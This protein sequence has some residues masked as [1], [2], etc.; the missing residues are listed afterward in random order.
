MSANEELNLDGMKT[1]TK[2]DITRFKVTEGS[3]IYRIL[4]PFGTDH[5]RKA[6]R[7]IQLHWGFYKADG[8]TSPLPCSYPFE[9]T[10]PICNHVKDLEGMADK[11]K[12]LGNT[13]TAEGILKDVSGIKVKRSFLLNAANKN[14][15]V[16]V[17]EIPK[18]AHDQMI[19]LMREYLNKYGKNPT[20]LKDG[21]WF[22]FSRSGKGFNTTYKVSIN[23][24]MVTLE[25]GDQVEK[26][27]RS[28]LAQN[29]QDNYEQLAY[30]IHTMYKPI[31]STDLR[32]IL[33]GEAID[34]VIVR[35][36]KKQ[37]PKK[38]EAPVAPATSSAKQ[39]APA[40]KAEPKK[41]TA[42]ATSVTDPDLDNWMEMLS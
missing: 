1:G 26:V 23:K 6:S 7:Q 4:P 20:S 9:G 18:T 3:H 27:D 41:E 30:D 40:T 5:Q 11:E 24:S 16:G 12:S 34:E 8:T 36:N 35:E 21:V 14:G 39:A 37:E 2:R 29:I 28:P 22:V 42:P 19:E 25:D 17:L 31:K 32:R 33:D 15:E 13:E 10:C 38:E